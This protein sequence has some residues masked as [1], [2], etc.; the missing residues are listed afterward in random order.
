MP[1][2]PT[3]QGIDWQTEISKMKFPRY[4][5]YTK[6]NDEFNIFK[7][8]KTKEVRKSKKFDAV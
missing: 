3:K 8:L 7:I 4:W 2:T 6:E 1:L 5:S